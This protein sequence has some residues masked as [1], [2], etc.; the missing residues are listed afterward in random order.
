MADFVRKEVGMS[1]LIHNEQ[2]KSIAAFCVNLGVGGMV[3]GVLAPLFSPVDGMRD[4]AMLA[5]PL[6]PGSAKL[7]GCLSDDLHGRN[8]FLTS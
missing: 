6:A 7:R 5:L 4:W 8:R 3:V 2:M 1:N